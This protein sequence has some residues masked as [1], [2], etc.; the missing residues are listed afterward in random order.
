MMNKKE[1]NTKQDR[2]RI[3]KC[4]RNDC[5]SEQE[6]VERRGMKI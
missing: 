6:I 2:V 1:L 5:I 4:A 3:S